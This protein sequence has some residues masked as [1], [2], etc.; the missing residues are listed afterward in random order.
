MKLG[1]SSEDLQDCIF[2]KAFVYA[3]KKMSQQ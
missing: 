3:M 2:D 1:I